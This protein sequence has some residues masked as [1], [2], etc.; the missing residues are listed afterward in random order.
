MKVCCEQAAVGEVESRKNAKS[1]SG[2]PKNKRH[3]SC[4]VFCFF[5]TQRNLRDLKP[6]VKKLWCLCFNTQS[7]VL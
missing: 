4:G 6:T 5:V 3:H 1:T 2:G 7:L